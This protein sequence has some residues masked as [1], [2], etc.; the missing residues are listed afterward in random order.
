MEMREVNG[1]E[2]PCHNAAP[3]DCCSELSRWRLIRNGCLTVGKLVPLCERGL[4][5]TLMDG[6]AIAHTRVLE[7][8]SVEDRK[9]VQGVMF[10]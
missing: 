10:R 9:N 6:Y 4:F 5:A 8:E 1:V 7:L 2:V 3:Q